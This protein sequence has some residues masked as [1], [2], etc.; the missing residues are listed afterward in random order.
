MCLRGIEISR[1]GTAGA[2][3]IKIII[4]QSVVILASSSMARAFWRF[5][6][7]LIKA[8][9]KCVLSI[10]RILRLVFIGI[11]AFGWRNETL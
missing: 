10:L 5:L 11:F 2:F 7:Q 1:I 8:Q 9:I 6:H 3:N 4:E